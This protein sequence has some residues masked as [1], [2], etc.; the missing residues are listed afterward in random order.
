LG[1]PGEVLLVDF[2]DDGDARVREDVRRRVQE[3]RRAGFMVITAPGP[4]G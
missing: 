4:T 3:Y 2:V 1:A